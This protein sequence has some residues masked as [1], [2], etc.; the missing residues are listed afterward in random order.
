MELLGRMTRLVVTREAPPGFYLDG[1][2]RGEI[3]LPHRYAP[4]GTRRGSEVDVFVYRDSEDRLVATTEI[5][6]IQVGEF[7]VLS[8]V[9]SHPSLGAFLDWGL[10]KDLLLP[11]REQGRPR[12][13]GESVVVHVHIDEASDRI[14]ASTRLHR[15]AKPH[16]GRFA[17]E[18]PVDLLVATETPLGYKVIIEKAYLGQLYRNELRERLSPGQTLR[19]YIREVRP[20][21]R[22][23]VSLNRSGLGR[24]VPLGDFILQELES[25]GGSLPYHDGSSPE[26]I[27]AAFGVSKKAFKQ[28]VGALYRQQKIRLTDGGIR[29]V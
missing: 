19:G 15:W 22:V 3:L 25:R 24:L 8:V 23:D 29:R 17:P 14:V 11:R 16:P 10:S 12:Q 9:G 27:R 2:E 28:A 26:E 7:G 18:H 13:V 4:E 6:R 5:P 20:D 1:F 21:G